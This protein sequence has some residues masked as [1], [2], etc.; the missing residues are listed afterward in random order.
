M[1][2]GQRYCGSFIKE[3]G[4]GMYDFTHRIPEEEIMSEEEITLFCSHGTSGFEEQVKTMS[5][6]LESC[7][8]KDGMTI[9]D[10]GSGPGILAVASAL[11]FPNSKVFGMDGDSRMVGFAK[12]FAK[13][14]NV[15]D[16]VSFFNVS[17]PLCCDIGKFDFVFSR[18][19]LHHFRDPIC[20]WNTIIALSKP[21]GG[22]LIYDLL[23]PHNEEE[24]ID[25]TSN[26]NEHM[27]ELHKK[28]FL[29]SYWIEEIKEQAN[30]VGLGTVKLT[31]L[32]NHHFFIYR[33]K[34][35]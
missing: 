8:I 29:S 31:V 5:C 2:C 18:S 16:R 34:E 32:G 27:K 14:L 21:D 6:L 28:S 23:R 1:K 4:Y 12:D 30:C 15:E 20:F 33:A 22:F 26:T 9:M 11:I 10:V 7:N 17:A 3:M 13:R 19:T 35:T 24:L 25:F